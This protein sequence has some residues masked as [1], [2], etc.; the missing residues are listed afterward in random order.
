VIAIASPLPE[1]AEFADWLAGVARQAAADGLA[2]LSA[3]P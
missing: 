2:A 1:A 3:Q